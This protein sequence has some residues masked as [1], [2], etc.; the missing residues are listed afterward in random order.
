[1]PDDPTDTWLAALLQRGR[2]RSTRGYLSARGSCRAA[3][4]GG[5]IARWAAKAGERCQIDQT[6][7]LADEAI[8]CPIEQN[9]RY[10]AVAHTPIAAADQR[11]RPGS[12]AA[13][14]LGDQVPRSLLRRDRPAALADAPGR[15]R[16]VAGCRAPRVLL[17]LRPTVTV[18]LAAARGHGDHG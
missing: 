9:A 15:R 6:S 8:R 2:R 18:H 1:M 17:H 11:P 10:A 7:S 4:T 16:G 13:A 12:L 5:V 14:S 3:R